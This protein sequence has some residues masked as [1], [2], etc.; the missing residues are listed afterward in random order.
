MAKI[1]I[2]ELNKLLRQCGIG[3]NSDEIAETPWFEVHHTHSWDHGYDGFKGI[4]VSENGSYKSNSAFSG[5]RREFYTDMHEI[6]KFLLQ[7]FYIQNIQELIAA[8]CFRCYQFDYNPDKNDIYDEIYA[9]LKENGIRKNEF[10]GI[11]M[12]PEYNTKQI[13]MIVE[14]AFR[15]VSQLCI[16]APTQ[17]VLIVPNH[18]FGIIFYAENIID[19]KQVVLKL[20]K[21]FT[22][23]R[24]FES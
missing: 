14:G 20:L 5:T 8:P 4:K 6:L 22:N 7:Y 3:I 23:L 13:E 19:E 24:Y 15:G 1:R 16:F 9:F 10:S 17:G 2:G 12:I 18:H 11:H 21:R